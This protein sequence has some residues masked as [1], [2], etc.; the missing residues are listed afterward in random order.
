MRDFETKFTKIEPVF[1]KRPIF[2]SKLQCLSIKYE[3]IKLLSFAE[4]NNVKKG[5]RL[6]I[7]DLKTKN[8]VRKSSWHYRPR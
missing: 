6:N 8:L 1:K 5:T 3:T 7:F 2:T 4:E